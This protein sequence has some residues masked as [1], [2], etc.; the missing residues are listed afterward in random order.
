MGAIIVVLVTLFLGNAV[1]RWV[2]RAW[3][4]PGQGLD[5]A[6]TTAQAPAALPHNGQQPGSV[7][8]PDNVLPKTADELEN[9]N[10]PDG[11]QPKDEGSSDKY[12]R[13]PQPRAA[14][15]AGQQAPQRPGGSA[16]SVPGWGQTNP[17]WGQ[18]VPGS[19]QAPNGWGPES[20][21]PPESWRPWGVW[22]ALAADMQC[23]CVTPELDYVGAYIPADRSIAV[24]RVQ[25][26]TVVRVFSMEGAQ[27][28]CLA[29]AADGKWAASG[30]EDGTL[31]LMSLET[32][33]QEALPS[34]HN[35]VSRL[36][37]SPDGTVLAS[38]GLDGTVNLWSIPGRELKS[39]LFGAKVGQPL[40]SFSEDGRW[41]MGAGSPDNLWLARLADN[42]LYTLQGAICRDGQGAALASVGDALFYVSASR[43]NVWGSQDGLLRRAIDVPR[44]GV[45][46]VACSRDGRLVACVESERTVRVYDAASGREVA[47]LAA[48]SEALQTLAFSPDGELLVAAAGTQIHIW[49]LANRTLVQ[50]LERHVQR[51]Q[52]LLY[53][54]DG[55]VL[56]SLSESGEV[57]F[58][59]ALHDIDRLNRLASGQP[60]K[61]DEAK[62]AWKQ[63]FV[64]KRSGQ[65]TEL[66]FTPDGN[67]LMAVIEKAGF[68]MWDVKDW[69]RTSAIDMTANS[70]DVSALSADGR[71]MG[72]AFFD[73]VSVWNM[74]SGRGRQIG[75]DAGW[76]NVLAFHPDGKR[77][78]SG[79]REG[80][81]IVWRLQGGRRPAR[82][83]GSHGGEVTALAFSPDGKYLASGSETGEL[84]I[85]DIDTGNL[86]RL[87]AAESHIERLAFSQDGKR[88]A[89]GLDNGSAHVWQFDSFEPLQ[90]V[91]HE[92][93]LDFAGVALSPDGSRLATGRGRKVCVWETNSG[94]ELACTPEIEAP[95]TQMA[96]NPGLTLFAIARFDGNLEVLR[97]PQAA[98]SEPLGAPAA[99]SSIKWWIAK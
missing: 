98:D 40:F 41:L 11:Y 28:K 96:C 57:C 68:F 95:I 72:T 58:W 30:T 24:W 69:S 84:R 76:V 18:N 70:V 6:A 35:S 59:C 43:L 62:P 75:R 87:V 36:A 27:V 34:K 10:R 61:A 45:S 66:Q 19:G 49:R 12:G 77:L 20:L 3:R 73:A 15:S 42:R 71:F 90:E 16:N 5:P 25:D 74:A 21:A 52:R 22:R 82:Q 23:V 47:T 7:A 91:Q 4:G 13:P 39:T 54:P 33:S 37:F 55:S 38:G 85:W 67:H 51:P 83:I 9:K 50:T 80:G 89:A 48:P 93:G 29:L 86:I 94:D 60:A 56:C 63:E 8:R 1:L 78:V 92:G 65:C 44:L 31:H 26:G 17:G 79:T 99:L 53:T 32:G 46:P 97:L 64:F 14:P 81:I 88:L 2:G